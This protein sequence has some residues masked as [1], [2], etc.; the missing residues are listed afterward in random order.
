MSMA[1]VFLQ[2]DAVGEIIES[3]EY[4]VVF[5]DVDVSK[6]Y[7]HLLDYIYSTISL[8]NGALVALEN[9]L[10]FERMGSGRVTGGDPGAGENG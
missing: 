2:K 9:S 10:T 5:S 6:A 8:W 4:R 3:D 7:R 1:F